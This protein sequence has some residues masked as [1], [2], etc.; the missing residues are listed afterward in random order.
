MKYVDVKMYNKPTVKLDVFIIPN[1]LGRIMDIRYPG[2]GYYT[3]LESVYNVNGLS[4]NMY[5]HLIQL[6]WTG[7]G[8]NN[9]E[10]HYPVVIKDEVEY[11]VRF[12]AYTLP[13]DLV[14]GWK[15]GVEVALDM[16]VE[17]ISL[18]DPGCR[19]KEVWTLMV[20]PRQKDYRYRSFGTFEDARCKVML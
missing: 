3:S 20:T 14:K 2:E 5:S 12:S 16:P 4:L 7:A 10:N 18:A 6:W 1:K 11:L 9:W 8:N 19:K 17:L 15:E 13:Y